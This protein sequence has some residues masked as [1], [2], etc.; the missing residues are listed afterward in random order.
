M[1]R[2]I[3]L[4]DDDLNICKVTSLYLKR[5]G[6]EIVTAYDGEQAIG[7]FQAHKVDAIIL[8]I[9]LPKLDGRQVCEKIRTISSV[10]II[11]LTA[12]GQ[13]VDRIEGL[14]L[15]ADDYIVK[16]FDP[17]EL[18]ARLQ[19]V[20]RRTVPEEKDTS[21]ELVILGSLE[22]NLHS[23]IVSING[24]EVKLPRKEFELLVF[25][26]KHPNRVFTRDELIERIWGFD[27]DGEDRVIDLYIK[28]LRK[29]LSIE[30][31]PSFAIKTV[32]GVGY[33]LE[34]T[35]L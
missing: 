13:V 27:F 34:A 2:K 21:K 16:P 10:P 24:G 19:A 17:N 12:R 30:D 26:A 4:V 23:H 5:A 32:W 22:I 31:I 20:L 14:Q 7:Q 6:F 1:P 8:D 11:M 3:L 18:I 35:S 33:Q 15:G 25:L 29:K 28:R 9:M